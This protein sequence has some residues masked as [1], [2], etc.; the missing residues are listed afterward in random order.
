MTLGEHFV[1]YCQ[2]KGWTIGTEDTFDKLS[3]EV[4]I[5]LNNLEE[6]WYRA[7]LGKGVH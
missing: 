7:S 4:G 6:A 1:A 3:K 2:E 5:A